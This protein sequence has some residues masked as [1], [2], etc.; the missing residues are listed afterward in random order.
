MTNENTS[1][2]PKKARGGKFRKLATGGALLLAI[3]VAAH[4]AWVYSG[5]NQWESAFD[6]LRA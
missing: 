4:L 5:S 2:E 1:I 3:A 6:K